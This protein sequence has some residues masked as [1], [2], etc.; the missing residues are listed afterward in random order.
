MRSKHRNN[1]INL[2]GNVGRD[3]FNDGAE[4]L[5]IMSLPTAHQK[6]QATEPLE[7][8][9][10]ATYWGGNITIGSN[11]QRFFVDFDSKYPLPLL[12]PHPDSPAP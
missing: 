9:Q 6:R 8:E 11:D 5:P 3:A 12:Q 2:Q 4:I 10:D 1:L 7:D